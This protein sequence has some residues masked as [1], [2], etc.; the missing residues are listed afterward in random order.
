M[1]ENSGVLLARRPDAEWFDY[2]EAVL[3]EPLAKDLRNDIVHGLF[4]RVGGVDAAL[5]IHAACHLALVRL[6]ET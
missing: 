6:T 5:L 2:L 3:C 4:P 1:R